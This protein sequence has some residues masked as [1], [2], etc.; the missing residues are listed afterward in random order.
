MGFFS[1][2]GSMVRGFFGMFVG[3]LEEKNPELLF[4]DIKNQVEKARKEAE[5]QIVEIQTN[6]ELIKIEMKNSEKNLN[7]VKA[8]VEA[9]Q[10]QGDMDILVELL[11]QEEELQTTYETHKATYDNAM[12][13]VARIREDFKIF[14]S[15]MNAK[16]NELK[17]LKS[18]AKMAAL[19]ENINSV[20][21]K[22]SSKNNRVGSINDSMDRAREIVNKKTT[23]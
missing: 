5:H 3:N 23:N 18:Q 4:E 21:A 6:A 16:L 8:R 2:L 22:Y 7:A 17:T 19:R 15:E 12:V 20:N 9:A 11:V 10:R 13:E 14:E 1:R